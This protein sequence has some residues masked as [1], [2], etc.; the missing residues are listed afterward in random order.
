MSKMKTILNM[1]PSLTA[2]AL[3]TTHEELQ[4]RKDR[5]TVASTKFRQSSGLMIDADGAN[6][7]IPDLD[8][9]LA[10][11]R[12][13]RHDA[14]DPYEPPTSLEEARRRT[15]D[16]L[17]EYERAKEQ[18]KLAEASA[19]HEKLLELFGDAGDGT[20]DRGLE[21]APAAP[22]AKETPYQP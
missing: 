14:G 4:E 18:Q 15:R 12:Q 11:A 20:D 1:L 13:R 22:G 16:A 10:R 9:V 2:L 6:D 19:M 21:N 7:E 8:E 3:E 17:A 5:V